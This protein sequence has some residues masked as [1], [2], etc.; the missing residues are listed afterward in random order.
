MA[1]FYFKKFSHL[2]DITTQEDKNNVLQFLYQTGSSW[3]TTEAKQIKKELM[4]HLEKSAGQLKY[5]PNINK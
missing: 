5:E 3:D 4:Q 2:T 1:D